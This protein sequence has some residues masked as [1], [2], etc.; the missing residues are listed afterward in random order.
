VERVDPTKSWAQLPLPPARADRPLSGI[1]EEPSSAH[2]YEEELDANTTLLE[3]I[4]H[5]FRTDTYTLMMSIIAAILVIL[6][7]LLFYLG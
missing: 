1:D 3:R 7:A 5:T 4:L 6:L 2:A